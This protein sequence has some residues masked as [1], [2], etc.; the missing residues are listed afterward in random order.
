M[1]VPP[2][3]LRRVR[4]KR[5]IYRPANSNIFSHLIDQLQRNICDLER[6]IQEWVRQ[7]GQSVK[8]QRTAGAG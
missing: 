2:G 6:R 1:I 8:K 4:A 3:S 5:R 7:P